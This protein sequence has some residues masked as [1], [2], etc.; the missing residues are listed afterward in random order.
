[1]TALRNKLMLFPRILIGYGVNYNETK[2][3][4]KM[5]KAGKTKSP[6]P[7]AEIQNNL[8]FYSKSYDDLTSSQKKSTVELQQFKNRLDIL[9]DKVENISAAIEESQQYSYRY[10]VKL[11]GIPDNNSSE[12]ASETTNLCL[13]LFQKLGVE[14]TRN[15]VEITRVPSRS[16]RPTPRPIICKFVRRIVKEETIKARKNICKVTPADIGLQGQDPMAEA[17]IFEHLTPGVQK[18]LAEARKFQLQHGLR[19]CWVK[20]FKVYLRETESSRPL[21]IKSSS[22]LENLRISIPGGSVSPRS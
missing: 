18:L 9:S 5:A 22:D 14:I 8:E 13:K 15:D 4:P 19:F 1:M 17:K 2:L 10:N 6:S 3:K 20:N 12:S 21:L 16:A 7:N 11:M